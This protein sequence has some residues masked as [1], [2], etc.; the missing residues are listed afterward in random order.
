MAKNMTSVL[1]ET[2]IRN[3]I[4]QIKEDPERSIRNIV[5]M[6]LHFANGR[7]QQHFLS[8][9]QNML[10]NE[11][12]SYYKLIPDL[13]HNIDEERIITFGMNV[14]YNSCTVGA[15]KI[16]D[17]ESKE[18]YNIPWTISLELTGEQYIHYPYVYQSLI[19]QGRALGIYTWIIHS[20]GQISY[21]LELADAFPDCAF[22]IFCSA[23]ELTGEVLDDAE[24]I[25]NIMFI[26]PYSDQSED[27]YKQLRA[28]NFLYSVSYPYSDIEPSHSDMDNVLRDM[29]KH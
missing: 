5:D 18:H 9:A 23:N 13:I 17:I 28:R 1:I 16:R 10:Q 29:E 20:F 22:P 12:S 15:Q 4:R 3:T 14:G 26:I 21:L 8:A 19:N 27:I 11:N 25:K 7:F 24:S 2:T 6:A